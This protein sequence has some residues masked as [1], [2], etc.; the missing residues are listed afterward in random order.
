MYY[1]NSNGLQHSCQISSKM[2]N[3]LIF[4][5]SNLIPIRWSSLQPYWIFHGCSKSKITSLDSLTSNINVDAKNQSTVTTGCLDAR[6]KWQIHCQPFRIFA[7]TFGCIKSLMNSW[8][9]K[10]ICEHQN[11]RAAF[12]SCCGVG[13]KKKKWWPH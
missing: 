5:L 8:Y 1:T 3:N 12:T 4:I 10:H 11:Q 2:D 7:Y 9:C 6:K 13:E